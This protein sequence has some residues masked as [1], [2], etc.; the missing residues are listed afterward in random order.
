MTKFHLQDFYFA[1][2]GS[3]WTSFSN[4]AY[5]DGLHS[6]GSWFFSPYLSY[7]E[8][9]L[10]W[11]LIFQP[12]VTLKHAKEGT[13]SSAFWFALG[14]KQSYT[15]KKASQETVR[16]THLYTYSFNKGWCLFLLVLPMPVFEVLNEADFSSFFFFG[17]IICSCSHVGTTGKFQV[18]FIITFI[19]AE[20]SFV[21]VLFVSNA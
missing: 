16:D 21:F 19:Q 10:T 17:L 5:C 4:L 8:C 6:F 11:M 13:E 2:W 7:L 9:F 1:K 14:G 18:H 12:G 20:F 15:S 3:W